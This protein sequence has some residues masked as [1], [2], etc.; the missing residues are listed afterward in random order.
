MMT[1]RGPAVAV[2]AT[3]LATSL[4]LLTAHQG[5]A[6]R[7]LSEVKRDPSSVSLSGP[8]NGSS[9]TV[10]CPYADTDKLSSLRQSRLVG[11]GVDTGV[12][13]EGIQ[14]IV[15]DDENVDPIRLERHEVD[16]CQVGGL[17]EFTAHTR[18]ATEKPQEQ[19]GQPR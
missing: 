14:W 13:D 1:W 12:M 15:Y 3:T 17:V 9:G 10:V 11:A 2:I 18:F 19:S 7:I 16:L 8:V 6:D 5:S 4:V